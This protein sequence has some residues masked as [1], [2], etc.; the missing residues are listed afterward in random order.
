MGLNRQEL[1]RITIESYLLF[2]REHRDL[3]RVDPLRY[4]REASR[5]KDERL[6][7]YKIKVYEKKDNGGR[8][9]W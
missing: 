3:L 6:R 9:L 5:F 2:E 1:E 4:W 8:N 7:E